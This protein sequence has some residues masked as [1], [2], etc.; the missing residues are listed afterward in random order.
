MDKLSDSFKRIF[1]SEDEEEP[2]EE[3]TFVSEVLPLFHN[4]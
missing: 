4:A 3:Q 1:K 2:E